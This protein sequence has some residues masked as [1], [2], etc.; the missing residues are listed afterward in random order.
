MKIKSNNKLYKSYT[1]ASSFR[2]SPQQI[3]FGLQLVVWLSGRK[4]AHCF[5]EVRHG[6]RSHGSQLARLSLALLLAC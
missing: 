3:R 6:A 1:A 4:A 5:L 2:K